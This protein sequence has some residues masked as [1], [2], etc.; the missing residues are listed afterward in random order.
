MQALLTSATEHLQTSRGTDEMVQE[1]LGVVRD[2]WTAKQGDA[3]ILGLR[4]R[5]EDLQDEIASY[6]RAKALRARAVQILDGK[7]GVNV[8]DIRRSITN[9]DDVDSETVR[10]MVFGENTASETEGSTESG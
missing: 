9:R 8:P 2:L 1:R 6:Q 3:A 10:G 5:Q 4:E 7:G